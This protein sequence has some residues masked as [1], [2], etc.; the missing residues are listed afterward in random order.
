MTGWNGMDKSQELRRMV[1]AIDTDHRYL[2]LGWAKISINE[3]VLARTAF[4]N[5]AQVA[6][7]S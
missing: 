1:Q 3:C 5:G 7:I 6:K 4:Q 2:P